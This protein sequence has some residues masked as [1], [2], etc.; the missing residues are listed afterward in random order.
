[1]KKLIVASFVFL[2]AACHINYANYHVPAGY[3]TCNTSWDCP[4][5]TYCGF[6]EV[7]SY[8]VCRH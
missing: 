7:D 2:V 3:K 5:G 8:A 1:M 6:V 4:R